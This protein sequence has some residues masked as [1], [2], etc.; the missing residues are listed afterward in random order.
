MSTTTANRPETP[1]GEAPTEEDSLPIDT[2]IQVQN[3]RYFRKYELTSIPIDY[4][5]ELMKLKNAIE[6]HMVTLSNNITDEDIERI[7]N[8][9]KYPVENEQ[10]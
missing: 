4:I 2:P 8:N 7:E 9:S 6:D 5:D 1:P 10:F 3:L